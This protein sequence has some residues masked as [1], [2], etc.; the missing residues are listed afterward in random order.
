MVTFFPEAWSGSRS[1]T[2]SVTKTP[3]PSKGARRCGSDSTGSYRES[4]PIP[5][6]GD[7]RHC[8]PVLWRLSREMDQPGRRTRSR[9]TAERERRLA[10]QTPA[11]CSGWLA[12]AS[13]STRPRSRIG[14]GIFRSSVRCLWKAAL[15]ALPSPR[16][17]KREGPPRTKGDRLPNPK[18]VIED[19]A[20]HPAELLTVAFPIQTGRVWVRVVRDVPWDQGSKNVPVMVVQARDPLGRRRDDV[21]ASTDPTASVADS[22]SGPR[23]TR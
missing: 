11:S 15:Y 4:P 21:P 16:G 7:R 5:V 19:A 8:P 9:S 17:P 10:G 22:V 14:R 12:T 18:A 20:A 2:R 23:W 3:R 13:G 6:R 1:T